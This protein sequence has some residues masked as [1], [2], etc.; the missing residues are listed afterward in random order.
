VN[1]LTRAEAKKW[2]R[3]AGLA[4]TAFI[5][6]L[7]HEISFCSSTNI[8]QAPPQ[9]GDRL[10]KISFPIALS[11]EENKYLGLGQRKDFSLDDIKT[12]LILIDF[13][14]TN[15][16]FCIQSIPTMNEIYK[17]VEKDRN[18]RANVKMLAVA[19]GGTL[20]EVDYF[21]KSFGV[22]F[23]ILADPEYKA[24]ESVG[25]PRVPFLIFA[26]QDRQGNWVVVNTKVGLMGIAEARAAT[27]LEEDVEVETLEGDIVT[28]ES[29]I[30]ELKVFLTIKPDALKS[31]TPSQ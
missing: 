20:T 27:Y 13:I 12:K 21:K 11:A 26:R 10:P 16:H 9:L 4:S 31:K 7:H 18:L 15:C 1:T 17:A 23:P 29:F 24:H 5:F 2:L 25:E 6:F 3:V 14:G 8:P 22:L 28:L 19:A 30:N